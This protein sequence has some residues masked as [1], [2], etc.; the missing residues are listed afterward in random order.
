MDSNFVAVKCSNFNTEQFAVA[1]AYVY[2]FISADLDTYQSAYRG[3]VFTSVIRA[4]LGSN[5]STDGSAVK[6][7]FK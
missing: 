1:V 4:H 2:A 6:C 5:K 7:A 3:A